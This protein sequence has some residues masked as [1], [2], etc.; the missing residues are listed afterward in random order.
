MAEE[1]GGGGEF[2]EDDDIAPLLQEVDTAYLEELKQRA[3][4]EER[5]RAQNMDPEADPKRINFHRLLL[6][7]AQMGNVDKAEEVMAQMFDAGLD[8][9]PRWGLKH[10]PGGL[11]LVLSGRVG[12]PEPGGAISIV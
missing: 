8:P 12:C 10:I 6:N 3:A 7:A 9:G 11:H 1:P 5:V 2:H 4:E